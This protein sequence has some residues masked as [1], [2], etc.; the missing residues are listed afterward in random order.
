VTP[1]LEPEKQNPAR[2]PGRHIGDAA[3]NSGIQQR[4]EIRIV[5]MLADDQAVRPLPA[6]QQWSIPKRGE[7]ILV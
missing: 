4:L 7:A 6:S 2:D 3:K 5:D 1:L